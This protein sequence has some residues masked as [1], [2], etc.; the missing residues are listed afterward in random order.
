MVSK[1]IHAFDDGS[2]SIETSS[3]IESLESPNS[4]SINI[5][6][7]ERNIKKSNS[8]DNEQFKMTDNDLLYY[9]NSDVICFGIKKNLLIKRITLPIVPGGVTILFFF[10]SIRNSFYLFPLIVFGCCLILF[11]NFP[12]LVVQ[13]N[14]KP[15]Y[16]GK[17]LFIDKDELPYL[18]LSPIESQKFLFNIKWMLIFLYSG[19]CSAL[20]DYWLFKTQNTT[21]YFEIIGVTGGILKI[22]QLIAHVGGSFVLSRTRKNV[23]KQSRRN[24][25]ESN[26]N[27][28]S[29]DIVDIWK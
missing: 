6:D 7:L 22:F 2:S 28:T 26:I 18:D 23:I 27:D 13:S 5:H 1:K 16:F 19:L 20:S 9:D 12:I 11:M 4:L 8:V 17:D 15:A 25:K 14:I 21:S 10:P 3:D 29:S 24:I